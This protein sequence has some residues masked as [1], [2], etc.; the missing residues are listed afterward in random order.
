MFLVSPFPGLVCYRSKTLDKAY[1]FSKC[2]AFR[3]VDEA[4]AHEHNRPV[5]KTNSVSCGTYVCIRVCVD[6]Q[7]RRRILRSMDNRGTEKALDR[8]DRRTE[9]RIIWEPT[10]GRVVHGQEVD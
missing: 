2:T 9:G 7:T 10:R 3:N 4:G 8:C 5:R 6:P 1:I